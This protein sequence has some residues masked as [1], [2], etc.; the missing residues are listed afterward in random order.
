[1]KIIKKQKTNFIAIESLGQI[2]DIKTFENSKLDHKG[3]KL[4]YIKF[5]GWI[6]DICTVLIHLN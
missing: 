1:M 3:Y 2:D 4:F 6:N 5:P